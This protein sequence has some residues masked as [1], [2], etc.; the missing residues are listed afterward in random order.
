MIE[1]INIPVGK[2]H[3]DQLLG[4]GTDKEGDTI[5]YVIGSNTYT[6]LGM[7]LGVKN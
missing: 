2:F 7:L 5:R 6:D 1:K 3:P 4:D